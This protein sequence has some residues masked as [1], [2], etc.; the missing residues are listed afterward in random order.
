MYRDNSNINLNSKKQSP[1]TLYRGLYGRIARKLNV[2]PSYVSRVARGDRRSSQ[3][4]NAL[5]QALEEINQQLR[6]DSSTATR[7]VPRSVGKAKR[8]KVLL[9][10]NRSRIRKQW[11]EHSDADPNLSGVKLAAGKRTAP[12][13]P[14]IEETIK[15]MNLSVKRMATASMKAAEQHGRLRQ[16]QGFTAISLVEEYNLVR[17]CVFALALEHLE[18]MEPHL[19]LQDLTQF[20]EALDL[21]TQRALGDYLAAN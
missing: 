21:Q 17:R 7:R 5:S 3:I 9:T 20:G 1:Q 15:V 6:R 13:L 12:I 19:L 2:D 8:L 10:Q 11:L 18:H 16:G 4:E 14:V